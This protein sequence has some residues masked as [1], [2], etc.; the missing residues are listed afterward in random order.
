MNAVVTKGMNCLKNHIFL[1][2][3]QILVHEKAIARADNA[4][5]RC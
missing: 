3:R 2:V 4:Q 1:T 5:Q